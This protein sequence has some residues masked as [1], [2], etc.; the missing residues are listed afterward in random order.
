MKVDRQAS[1]MWSHSPEESL[2]VKLGEPDWND[3]RQCS[4]CD[5]KKTVLEPNDSMVPPAKSLLD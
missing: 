3:E 4:A 5:F 2:T 1:A